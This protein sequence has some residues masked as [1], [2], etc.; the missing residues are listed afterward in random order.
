MRWVCGEEDTWDRGILPHP[1]QPPPL[2]S[3]AMQLSEQRE[4]ATAQLKKRRAG[5][6]QGLTLG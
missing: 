2:S 5:Y 3:V 6:D 1:E 4:D